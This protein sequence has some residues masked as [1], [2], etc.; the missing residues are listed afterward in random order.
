MKLN[1]FELKKNLENVKI[2]FLFWKNYPIFSGFQ[3]INQILN[4]YQQDSYQKNIS[5][6][7]G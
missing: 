3:I 2:F 4:T 6:L 1:K 5:E 7:L